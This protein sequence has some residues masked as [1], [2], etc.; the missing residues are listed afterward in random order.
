MSGPCCYHAVSKLFVVKSM[1]G[2]MC[3]WILNLL[4]ADAM[5]QLVLNGY[6]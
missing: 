3:K 1:V 2:M 4:A 6:L 5:L